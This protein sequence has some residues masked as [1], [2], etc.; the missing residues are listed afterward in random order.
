MEQT[1]AAQV[2]IGGG[3]AANSVLRA[4][5]AGAA[6]RLHVPPRALCTDNAA[7]IGAAARHVIPLVPGEYDDLDA[8]PTGYHDL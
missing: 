2:A 3:V 4:R 8:Y 1:G 6:G 7:M 5:L